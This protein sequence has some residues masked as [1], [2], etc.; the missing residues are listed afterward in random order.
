MLTKQIRTTALAAIV[1]LIAS[2]QSTG[3][4]Q[5]QSA[6]S[7]NRIDGAFGL[8]LGNQQRINGTPAGTNS[9]GYLY[10]VVPPIKNDDFV[11][12]F[13]N[14]TPKS[15]SL[16]AI[17]AF[18]KNDPKTQWDRTVILRGV[19]TEKYGKM[20]F[21]WPAINRYTWTRG[22]RNVEIG[23]LDIT[24]TGPLSFIESG[25][26]VCYTDT[27]LMEQGKHELKDIAD[28][29][30]NAKIKKADKTGL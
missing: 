6:Q 4:D 1:S 16:C 20:T 2:T 8:S 25:L 12:Y 3:A 30:V 17:I 14:I 11:K 7:T 5:R 10:A 19:M 13:I 15:N 22:D 29:A 28:A 9:Y 23:N 26:T 18:Q 24:K 21:E 27:K